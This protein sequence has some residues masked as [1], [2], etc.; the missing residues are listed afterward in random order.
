FKLRLPDGSTVE[1][2]ISK[3]EY[4]SNSVLHQSVIVEE[5]KKIGYWVYNSFKATPQVQPTRSVEVEESMAY[6]EENGIS[7]LIIDLR[8]NGGG[9]VAVAEQ[10]MKYLVPADATVKLMYTNAL[11]QNTDILNTE[12]HYKKTGNLSLEMLVFISTRGPST[13]N[14]LVINCLSPNM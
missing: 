9:S 4:Q 8:Y 3:E 6:F 11:I 14:E 2:T 7:E 10:I 12:Q 1:R 5:N 13:S